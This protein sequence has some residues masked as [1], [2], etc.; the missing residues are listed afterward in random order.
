[1]RAEIGSP[2]HPRM[3]DLYLILT[4]LAGFLVGI[5]AAWPR[6]QYGNRRSSQAESQLRGTRRELDRQREE[7]DRLQETL[8]VILGGF[9]HPVIITDRH[10][11]ILFANPAAEDFVG[12]HLGEIAGRSVAT[13]IQDH[14][15]TRLL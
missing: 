11:L 10:R 15:T 5:A 12:R 8:R 7:A 6:Q 4:G 3:N 1:M 14:D 13:F 2:R 9:P